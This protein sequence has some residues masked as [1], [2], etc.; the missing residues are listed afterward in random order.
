MAVLAERGSRLLGLNNN[1]IAFQRFL[2]SA[3]E[4]GKCRQI[5]SGDKSD[6]REAAEEGGN[7]QHTKARALQQNENGKVKFI[8]LT[9]STME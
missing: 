6:W 8:P 4:A 7:P 5:E 2:Y 3:L 1:E 9:D